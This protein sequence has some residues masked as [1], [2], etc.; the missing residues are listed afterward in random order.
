[1]DWIKMSMYLRI[2]FIYRNLYL[3]WRSRDYFYKNVSKLILNKYSRKNGQFFYTE[4]KTIS[5]ML[6]NMVIRIGSSKMR[7]FAN[8]SDAL[9]FT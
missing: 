3:L 4:G 1:M 5:I 9:S 2:M 7:H 6:I 8:P